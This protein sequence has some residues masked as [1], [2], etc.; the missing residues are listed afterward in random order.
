V[1]ADQGEVTAADGGGRRGFVS[2]LFLLRADGGIVEGGQQPLGVHPEKL[3][4]V[5]IGG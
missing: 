3:G 1:C 5:W 4:T 2:F